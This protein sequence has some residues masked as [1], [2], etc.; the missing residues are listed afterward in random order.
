MPVK[1]FFCYA[2][3]DEPLL[4]TLKTHLSPLK[5]KGLIDL[6]Y[7][8]EIKAGTQWEKE[9]DKHLNEANI[10]LLLVSPDFMNSDYCY[11][12]EMQ[13]AL[14]RD[15]RGEARVIPIILRPVYWQEALGKLQ[16]L[17]TDA[18][19]IVSSNWQ[20]Q[21]EAFLNVAEGIRTVI[22]ETMS[23]PTSPFPTIPALPI[24]TGSKPEQLIPK[25]DISVFETEQKLSSLSQQSQ[26]FQEERN[27][28]ANLFIQP[29]NVVNQQRISSAPEASA[30]EHV[31]IETLFNEAVIAQSNGNLEKAL[32]LY[33]QIRKLDPNFNKVQLTFH[34]KKLMDQFA[35]EASR[36]NDQKSQ[37]HYLNE[38]LKLDPGNIIVQSRLEKASSTY[39]KLLRQ[40]ATSARQSSNWEDEYKSLNEIL[41]LRP[42]DIEANKYFNPAK[43]KYLRKQA[44][45]AR[46]AASWDEEARKWDE[47]LVLLPKNFDS[48]PARFKANRRRAIA[49]KNQDHVP[50]YENASQLESEGHLD[51]ARENLEKLWQDAPYYGD[52]KRLARKVDMLIPLPLE[53]WRKT[54]WLIL[55]VGLLV[56]PMISIILSFL[57]IDS[58]IAWVGLIIDVIVLVILSKY[59]LLI[60]WFD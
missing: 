16:A 14:E 6:W 13:R 11:G 37:I 44:K 55:L 1:I 41:K 7:D 5:R 3:E 57:Q 45:K 40:R 60:D 48:F 42:K 58:T 9:I 15:Q 26:Y 33:Q 24:K 25:S 49:M 4:N 46:K 23:K 19:P 20:F 2:R 22:E 36:R 29:S 21:D 35:S 53:K 39:I 28:Q 47:L 27:T 30:Y 8:R 34:L 10:I 18:K 52:P 59:W 54:I 56:L 43:I 32:E 50:V 51:E 31:N 12:I 17:P 38:L